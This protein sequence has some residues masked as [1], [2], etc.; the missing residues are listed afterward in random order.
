M[1]ILVLIRSMRMYASWTEESA[2]ERFTA[3][4]VACPMTERSVTCVFPAQIGMIA[5]QTCITT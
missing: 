5:V 1:T 3:T 2:V 4:S